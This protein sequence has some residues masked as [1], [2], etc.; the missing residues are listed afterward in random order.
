MLHGPARCLYG[1]AFADVPCSHP[2]DRILCVARILQ[3]SLGTMG[4]EA[5]EA[6]LPAVIQEIRD[7][8]DKIQ[9]IGD[10]YSLA[11]FIAVQR[12]VGGNV[13]GCFR[14]ERARQDSNP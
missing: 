9:I 11:A 6:Y 8:D 1:G 13:S 14:R 7:S 10:K 2:P 5:R 4:I 3:E 12:V